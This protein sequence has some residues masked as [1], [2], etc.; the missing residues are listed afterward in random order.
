MV[1]VGRQ[2]WWLC[3]PL[4]CRAE[5]ET[6]DDDEEPDGHGTS[7]SDP[8]AAE[9]VRTSLHGE[10]RSNQLSQKAQCHW[11]HQH[12][13][14]GSISTM[15]PRESK[16]AMTFS[17]ATHWFGLTVFPFL[18]LFSENWAPPLRWY[19]PMPGRCTWG[20]TSA[21]PYSHTP[22]SC[23]G[24]AFL[25]RVNQILMYLLWGGGDIHYLLH[26]N[27]DLTCE[28][29]DYGLYSHIDNMLWCLRSE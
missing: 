26:N 19:L 10:V 28:V 24:G 22:T 15:S 7:D 9:A 1:F 27:P 23:Q 8:G 18:S 20:H 6:R 4:S 17:F 13:V 12:N 3:V 2:W 16:T 11:I 21:P 5:T 29:V 14:T 25:E